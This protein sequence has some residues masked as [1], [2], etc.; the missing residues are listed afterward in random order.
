MRSRT[1]NNQ[2]FSFIEVII[3]SSIVTM[4]FGALFASFQYSLKLITLS[5]A[6]QSAMSIANDRMEFFRSLPYDNVGTISGFP[7]GT[8]PQNSTTTLNGIDFAERVQVSYVD[9]PADGVGGSDANLITTDYKRV[10]LEYRWNVGGLEGSIVSISNIVPRSIETNV[11]GGTARI[12]VIDENSVLLPGARVRL[13]NSTLGYDVTVNSDLAGVALFSV[14]AGGDYEVSVSGP[15][16]GNDYSTDQT[17]VATTSNPNPVTVPFT[18][19]ESDISTLTFQIG[20]LSNLSIKLLSSVVEDS[21]DED[22]TDVSGVA[23]STSVE[24]NGSA[25]VLTNTAGVYDAYGE[26]YL[27]TIT[28]PSLVAWQAATVAS[29]VPSNT[30]Y[31]VYFLTGSGPY[32]LIPD[33]DLPGN[34]AGFNGTTIDL[35]MLDATLYP[36]VVVG[37][38]LETTDT[39]VTPEIENLSVFYRESETPLASETVTVRGDKVIG[40]DGGGLP[41]YKFSTSTVSSATGTVFLEDIEFDNYSFILPVG[42]D[43]AKGCPAYPHQQIAGVDGQVE[44]V[45]G[46]NNINS[47][48]V[49]VLDMALQPIPGATITLAR[50]GL[51]EVEVTGAC[52]QVYLRAAN[53]EE[54]DYTLNISAPGYQSHTANGLSINGDEVLQVTLSP[55]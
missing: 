31:R 3:V 53:T 22:F 27:D 17:Y 20:Q 40:T 48:R 45:V 6:K 13:F 2:G 24:S 28:P 1:T 41:I 4:V 55:L 21:Y 18:V 8:I 37:L 34:A 29:V 15:I 49:S 14:P 26:V 43:I 30:S 52:G 35:T 46:A 16:G 11:G 19:L 42:Y 39:A 12:N 54:T 10:R 7:L 50:T 36:S 9:D 44:L 33:S 23:S 51:N 32:T 25:L 5:R 38:V 47:L